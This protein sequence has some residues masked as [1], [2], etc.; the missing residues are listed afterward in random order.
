MLSVK[1]EPSWLKAAID[2]IPTI[3]PHKDATTLCLFRSDDT[4]IKENGR[5][6]SHIRLATKILKSTGI[7]DA[8]LRQPVMSQGEVK[9]L[10]G[11]LIRSDGKKGSLT[12]KDVVRISASQA[13]GYYDDAIV[14]GAAFPDAAEGSIV[15]YEYDVDE[16]SSWGAFFQQFTFQVQQPVL[17]AQFSL[18]LPDGWSVQSGLDNCAE[19]SYQ[20]SGNRHVWTARNLVFQPDEPMAPD[21][22]LSTRIVRANC[23]G[24]AKGTAVCFPNWSTAALWVA[25]IMDSSARPDSALTDFTTKLIAN[26]SG[27]LQKVQLIADFVRSQIRYVAVEIDK[28]RFAPRSANLT[29]TNRF[30]DCKDKVA[31]MRGMLKVAG[32]SSAAV[33]ASI[34]MPV[35][36]AVAS[37]LQFDHCIVGIPRMELSNIPALPL[38]TEG[39]W[40]F[41]DPTDPSIAFGR[42]PLPEY[43]SHMLIAS[44]ETSGLT[45]LSPL[46]GTE[47][48]RVYHTEAE[49]ASDGSLKADV[50]ISDYGLFAAATSYS[51]ATTPDSKEL[52]NLRERFAPFL[53]NVKLSEYTTTVSNDSVVAHFK[54]AATNS[55]L[56]SGEV[57]VLKADI[58]HE[59]AKPILKAK[60]RGRP[61][62]FGS[63]MVIETFVKWHL[64]K[65]WAL[66]Q[67]QPPSYDSCAAG[68]VLS[69]VTVSDTTVEYHSRQSITGQPLDRT[70]YATAKQFERNLEMTRGMRLMIRGLDSGSAK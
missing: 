12:D 62:S 65:R 59:D 18:E 5:A 11:W 27:T 9:N 16:S 63:P 47:F 49:L 6:I 15:A 42:L 66:S 23:F 31:L 22:K 46:P 33:L 7:Q 38:A 57:F 37:P 30:G 3:P 45:H 13:A 53:T 1:A 28:G 70:D 19:C 68:V 25:S 67:G 64:G 60:E 55:L 32:I 48:R 10:E 69:E 54:L 35:D 36:T 26:A 4:K 2:S 20:Q 24:T 29:F 21:W 44:R 17:F 51:W 41:F 61:I 39:E 34:D 58:V 50:T 8:Y 52:D 40:V 14:L 43:N 56:K